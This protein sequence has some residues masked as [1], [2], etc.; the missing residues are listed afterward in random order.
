M[1]ADADH[2][3]AVAADAALAP[4]VDLYGNEIDNALGAYGIDNRGDL[5]ERHSPGTKV[6]RLAAPS[7]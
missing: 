3:D 2:S 7:L 4:R 6:T 5:Y 1:P